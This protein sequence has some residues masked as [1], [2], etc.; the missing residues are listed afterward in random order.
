M[1]K[2]Q[3]VTITAV[4]HR[5]DEILKYADRVLLID[6]GK[7]LLNEPPRQFFQNVDLLLGKGVY[8]PQ[9]AQFAKLIFEDPRL[10]RASD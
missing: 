7:V 4:E 2:E 6:D 3:D 8:P 9:V 10:W 5:S 1:R